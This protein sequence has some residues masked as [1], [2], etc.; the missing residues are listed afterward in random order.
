MAKVFSI[1]VFAVAFVMTGCAEQPDANQ[2]DFTYG[3][4]SAQ[5]GE[6]NYQQFCAACHGDE[7][8]GDGP[9]AESL[10]T[11]VP[12]LTVI[13]K[14]NG[15]EF[16]WR[17]VRGKI[18]GRWEVGAHGTAEMPVWGYEFWIDQDAGDFNEQNV[19][20]ILDDLVDYLQSIQ[21]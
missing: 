16:P 13:A 15:G 7:G 12:D 21:Q 3:A 9:V 4:P 18:D 8:R 17:D 19:M 11:P 10:A 5:T 14:N 20:K 6:Q 2:E 1:M